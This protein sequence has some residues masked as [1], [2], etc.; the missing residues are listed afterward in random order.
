M[1]IPGKVVIYSKNGCPHCLYAKEFMREINVPFEEI[2]YSSEDPN[3][4][5]L[6]DA[7]VA[8]TGHKT[9]PQIFVGEIFLGGAQ[10]LQKAYDTLML[11]EMCKLIGI[12]IEMDF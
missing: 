5:E 4:P 2:F 7:L 8:K 3:Y 11:H 6:R 1:S 10:E 9:F 12:E